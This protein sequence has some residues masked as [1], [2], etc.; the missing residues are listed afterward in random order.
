VNLSIILLVFSVIFISELPD[1]SMFAS[2]VLS[3]RFRKLYVWL[4][5]ATA[6]LIHVLIATTAGHF[7]TLLPHR[8]LEAV[9]GG[10]FLVGAAL[11]IFGKDED[12]SDEKKKLEHESSRAGGNFTKAFMTSFA[13]VFLGEWGDIT[14]IATA[15]YAARYH[16]P[17]G[18]GVGA[19][20][21]LW[22]VAALGVLLGSKLLDH[23]PARTL[24][25]V[26]ALVLLIFAGVSI[27]AAIR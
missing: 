9:V 24:Q 12:E 11:L 27:A 6:F 10:L 1:K 4:G 7:L 23:I 20:A 15:N 19:V 22:S 13:V 26:T 14:Q 16:D 21:A 18:V 25:R 8:M 5:A 3:T 17:L 2:L